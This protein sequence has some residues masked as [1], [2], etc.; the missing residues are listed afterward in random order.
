MS[1]PAQLVPPVGAPGAPLATVVKRD[2]RTVPYDRGRIRARFE[3]RFSA[4]AMAR[5]YV[6]LYWRML[7][8]EGTRIRL[9]A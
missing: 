5:R 9:T 1:A 7:E 6:E 2:G 3:Q 4:A 8:Q